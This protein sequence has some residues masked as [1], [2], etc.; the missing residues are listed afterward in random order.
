MLRIIVSRGSIGGSWLHPRPYGGSGAFFLV[1]RN[2]LFF[3]GLISI[4]INNLF[5]I[6]KKNA[7]QDVYDLRS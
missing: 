6:K 3:E 7:E 1:K 5:L 4:N 2:R